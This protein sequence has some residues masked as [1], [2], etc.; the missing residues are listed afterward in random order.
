[1]GSRQAQDDRSID[2]DGLLARVVEL[3]HERKAEDLVS[4]D[5]RELV[6]YMD[7]LVI[8]TGRSARQ[9]RAIAEHVITQLKREHRVLPLS[10]AGLDAGSWVCVDFVDVVLHVFEPETRDH[11]DLEL[12]W[13]EAAR[14]E[15][16]A[17][18]GLESDASDP[19]L[20]D[21]VEAEAAEEL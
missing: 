19:D 18:A 8:C 4:L 10:R 11:Y 14:T 13:G 16:E 5:V 7:H 9:N 1:M 21:A 6:D 17:P 15:H 2:G 12:L 3:C 20:A